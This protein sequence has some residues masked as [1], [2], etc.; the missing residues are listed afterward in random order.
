MTRFGRL[1]AALLAVL[2]AVPAFAQGTT[3]NVQ[4]NVS[5]Q[6]GLALPGVTVTVTNADTGFSRS[7]QTDAPGE[8]PHRLASDRQLRRQ[9]RPERLRRAEPEG[10]RR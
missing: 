9:G 6:Q 3:G 4:G 2:V 5:D 7:A 8:V 10:R 1:A